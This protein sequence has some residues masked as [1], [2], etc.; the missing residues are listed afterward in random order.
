[1]IG[2]KTAAQLICQFGNLKNVITSA[3]EIKKTSI[4]ESIKQNSDRLRINYRLIKLDNRA[5]LP[6][7]IDEL[8]YAYTDNDITTNKVLSAIGLR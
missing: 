6:F 3:N 2:P 5:C 8:E 7:N 4:R 1:M